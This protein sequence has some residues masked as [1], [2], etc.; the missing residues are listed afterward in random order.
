M[1]ET[2]RKTKGFLR[3]F[4][5]NIWF[6]S[7]IERDFNEE[8]NCP[9]IYVQYHFIMKGLVKEKGSCV[10]QQRN[11]PK[12]S[13][14]TQTEHHSQHNMYSLTLSSIFDQNFMV[15]MQ[16]VS[17]GFKKMRLGICTCFDFGV[18]CSLCPS[19]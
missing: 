5:E 8:A 11:K 7:R 3:D 1:Y 9:S 4:N 12:L 10:M 19:C 13:N 6:S 17:Y 2:F 14:F 16:N 18:V 15:L